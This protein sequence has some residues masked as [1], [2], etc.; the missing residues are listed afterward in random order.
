MNRYLYAWWTWE[1]KMCTVHCCEKQWQQT[2]TA[3]AWSDDVTSKY[4]LQITGLLLKGGMQSII[5]LHLGGF[6]GTAKYSSFCDPHVW[7]AVANSWLPLWKHFPVLSFLQPQG[8]SFNHCFV[9]HRASSNLEFQILV[10]VQQSTTCYAFWD[11]RTHE[12]K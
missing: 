7:E 5:F 4:T 10:S 8:G 2:K 3:R 1:R 9:S 6:E 11:L 12:E